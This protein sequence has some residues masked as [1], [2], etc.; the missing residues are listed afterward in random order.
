MAGFLLASFIT[1]KI[2]GVLFCEKLRGCLCAHKQGSME[3]GRGL[4][5]LERPMVFPWHSQVGFHGFGPS[6]PQGFGAQNSFLA[7]VALWVGPTDLGENTYV[8]GSN[9]YLDWYMDPVDNG[10]PQ[11]KPKRVPSRKEGVG[12]VC[13]TCA[14][15]LPRRQFN[16]KLP[17]KGGMILTQNRARSLASFSFGPRS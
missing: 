16:V 5:R 11:A 14:F 4:K 2:G 9:T 8:W 7:A 1:P 17:I 10:L 12:I 6:Q 15:F 13:H 3:R